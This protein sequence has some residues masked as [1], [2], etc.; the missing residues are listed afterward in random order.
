[1][2]EHAAPLERD[3]ETAQEGQ[4]LVAQVFAA[5]KAFVA[6]FP[7]TILNDLKVKSSKALY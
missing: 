3:A 2:C 1:V 4:N 6:V 7:Y 5:R